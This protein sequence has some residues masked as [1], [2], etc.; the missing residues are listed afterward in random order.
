MLPGR[1][2]Y[3]AALTAQS[4]QT[5]M[6]LGHFKKLDNESKQLI[7]SF[8]TAITQSDNAKGSLFGTALLNAGT[9]NIIP[10]DKPN[11]PYAH[12]TPFTINHFSAKIQQ[13]L[14]IGLLVNNESRNSIFFISKLSEFDFA[15]VWEHFFKNPIDFNYRNELLKAAQES[16]LAF[17]KAL[18]EKKIPEIVND[19]VNLPEQLTT[20]Y[21]CKEKNRI[22]NSRALN[23]NLYSWIADK[24]VSCGWIDPY[25]FVAHEDGL[26]KL[27][28]EALKT[29]GDFAPE[30]FIKQEI[31]SLALKRGVQIVYDGGF[32]FI[33]FEFIPE[34]YLSHHGL[35]KEQRNEYIQRIFRIAHALKS[36]FEQHSKPL[37]KIFL[38]MNLTSNFKSHPVANPVQDI[39]GNTYSKIPCPFDIGHFW[40]PEVL[41]MFDVFHKIFGNVLPIAGVFFDFEMYHAPEQAGMYTDHMDF[42]DLAWKVYCSYT[43]NPQIASLAPLKKRVQY[44]QVHKKFT[45]YFTILER[46]SRDVG[47]AVKNY[48]RKKIPNLLFGAYAPT[49]PYSW[50]YRGIM[51]GLS[52][53]QEPL[54][55]ATFNTDY[56]SHDAWL[57]SHHINILHGPAIMLSKLRTPTDLNLITSLL[58]H[59]DFVWYN[60]PSRMVYQYNEKE[61]QKVWWGIEATPIKPDKLM[62][63]IN[64]QHISLSR[65]SCR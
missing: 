32:N 65:K 42:S 56:A 14:P 5:I 27:K 33:W 57:K 60:H 58:T 44:L 25:D 2:N 8:V 12:T 21:L 35:R 41:D 59:H 63:A 6:K 43:N 10:V 29:V 22:A 30:I 39:F 40:K 7:S 48:M 9:P 19:S 1:I 51:A 17:K 31:E 38:G 45:E 47:V 64:M 16:L 11:T 4:L 46:A 18:D 54:L 37:P 36:Y 53:P 28:K 50:F 34:W 23:A 49:L 24:P 62:R 52:T 13:A 55:L 20:A 26:H 61:L 3:T 15:D